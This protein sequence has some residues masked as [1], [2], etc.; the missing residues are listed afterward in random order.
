M[1]RPLFLVKKR[2]N[3]AVFWHILT[4]I[5]RLWKGEPDMA[6]IWLTSEEIKKREE[7]LEYLMGPRRLGIAEQL[8]FARAFGV[9][10]EDAVFGAAKNVQA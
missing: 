10:S 7:R 3:R 9:L 5:A 2:G 4:G 6:E 8:K 1:R